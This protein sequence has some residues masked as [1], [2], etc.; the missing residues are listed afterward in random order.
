MIPGISLRVEVKRSVN[1]G[2]L[3][4]YLL[5]IIKCTALISIDTVFLRQRPRL[6]S[7]NDSANRRD[8]RGISMIDL[9]F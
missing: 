8:E 2:D 3:E 5:E 7:D 1:N 4:R 6:L 9:F